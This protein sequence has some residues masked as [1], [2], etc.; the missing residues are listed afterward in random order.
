MVLPFLFAGETARPHFP[1]AENSSRKAVWALDSAAWAS[2]RA[3]LGEGENMVMWSEAGPGGEERPKSAREPLWTIGVVPRPRTPS[4]SD[5]VAAQEDEDF[6]EFDEDDFDDD[7][8]D[9]FEEEFD[10]EFGEDLDE[11]D[12]DED[13]LAEG[14]VEDDEEF[15][16]DFEANAGKEDD[17]DDNED[18]G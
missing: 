11:E 6:D 13:E 5:P 16:D 4:W 7:F 10:D 15:E 8:D 17:G 9:D 2:G 1:F 12:A 3:K 14:E 18:L